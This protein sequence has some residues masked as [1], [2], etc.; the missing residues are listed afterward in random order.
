[1]IGEDDGERVVVLQSVTLW[2]EENNKRQKSF[3]E[4]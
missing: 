1:M 2:E 3:W 4:K